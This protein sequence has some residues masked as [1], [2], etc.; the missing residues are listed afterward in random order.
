MTRRY[1]NHDFND[2]HNY[3]NNKGNQLINVTFKES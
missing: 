1:K 2:N 3:N